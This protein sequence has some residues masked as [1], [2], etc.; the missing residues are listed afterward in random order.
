M[1]SGTDRKRFSGEFFLVKAKSRPFEWPGDA[2]ESEI[3]VP[4]ARESRSARAALRAMSLEAGSRRLPLE[5]LQM[6][7]T[8]NRPAQFYFDF[9]QRE[10]RFKLIRNEAELRLFGQSVAELRDSARCLGRVPGSGQKARPSV[11][12][13]PSKL[14]VLSLLGARG[15]S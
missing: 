3:H 10:A 5:C 2:N 13:F 12:K 1:A 9:A 8:P 11:D 4:S 6:L 15:G 7:A 14:A